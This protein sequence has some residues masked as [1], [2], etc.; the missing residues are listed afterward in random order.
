MAK[1]SCTG[2]ELELAWRGLRGD[3]AAQATYLAALDARRLPLLLGAALTAPLLA[4]LAVAALGGL[5][6][7]A[8]DEAAAVL[9]ALAATPRFRVV[10]L[11]LAGAQKAELR[12]AWDAAAAAAAPDAGASGR[13]AAARRLFGV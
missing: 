12:G 7:A 6:R 4:S 1:Q 2:T 3:A 5:L 9:E 11:C 10:V 8:P 13:L